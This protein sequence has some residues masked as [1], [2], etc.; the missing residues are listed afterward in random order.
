M[1]YQTCVL[2]FNSPPFLFYLLAAGLLILTRLIEGPLSLSSGVPLSLLS[3]PTVKTY[4]GSSYN[5]VNIQ[6]NIISS[7]REDERVYGNSPL[8]SKSLSTSAAAKPAKISLAMACYERYHV[9]SN[10]VRE[11]NVHDVKKGG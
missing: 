1:Q 9:V 2:A 7:R 3:V 10:T 11:L 5:P 8:V 6:S 4:F